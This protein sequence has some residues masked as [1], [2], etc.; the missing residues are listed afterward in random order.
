MRDQAQYNVR[1][2]LATVAGASVPPPFGGK[3][4]QIMV[5]ADRTALEARGLT[6]MDVVHSLNDAN[7]IIPAGDA[8]I[9]NIDYFVGSN[10]MIENPS[11]IDDVPIRVGAGQAPVLVGDVGHADDA[12]QIQQNVVRIDG[13][14]SV[15]V[16]IL[17]QGNANTIAVVDG[18]RAVLPKIVGLPAGMHLQTIFDQ[19]GYIRDAIE[20]LQ[21]EAASAA[22]LASLVI[23]LFLSSFKSTL[24]IFVSIPLSILAAA[25]GLFLNG[26]TTNVMT[27][28][29]FALAIGRLVDNSVVV[30]ENVSRHLAQGKPPEV[31]ARDGAEEV[32]LP[33]LAS[34]V[35][36][37]IVFFPVMFLFGV[38]KYLFGALSLAVVLSMLASYVVAMTVIP[39]YCARFVTAA[40]AAAEAAGAAH[41]RLAW[42]ARAYE[43]FADRYEVWLRAA[44][45]HKWAVI[46][47]V[48][49]LFV[50]AMMGG[51][52][53]GTELFPRTDAGQ[54]IINLRTPPGSR[55]EVTEGLTAQV[56]QI[57]REVVPPHDLGTVVSNLGLAPGFSAIYSPNAASDS[58]FVM[59][60]LTPAHTGATADYVRALRAALRSRLP[61]VQAFFQSGSIIDAVLNFGLAA[62]IDVQLSG[63]DYTAL[64]S[65]AERVAGVVRQLPEV[66]DAFIPQ[67]SAYP[68]LEVNVDRMKAARLGLSQRD[69][70]TNLITALTSNQMIAP[71]IWIDPRTGNDYFLTVQYPEK[72]ISSLDTLLNIPVRG[73][74]RGEDH[75]DAILLR[76]VAEVS[77]KTQPAEA[78]HYN[79]QRVVDVLVAPRGDDLGGAQSG[80]QR[81]LSGLSLPSDIHVTYR[82]SVA[83]MQSSFSSFGFG[84][85]MALVLLYLVMVAQ[86]RSFLDPFIIMFSVPMGLIG[87]VATL[88]AT[89]TTLNIESCMGTIMMVGYRGVEFDPAGRFHQPT[90]ARRRP[91]AAGDRRGVARPHAADHHDRPGDRRRAPAHRHEAGHRLRG[92][93]AAGARRRGRPHRVHR[94]DPGARAG[95]LRAV[96]RAAPGGR[97]VNPSH[98]ALALVALGLVAA[99]CGAPA[100][101]SAAAPEPM[102]VAVARPQP[103]DV[104]RAVSLPGDVI[105]RSEADLYAKVTGYLTH[106]AV[107]KGDWVKKGQVLAELEVPELEQ[108]LKRARANLSVQRVTYERLQRVWDADHR[109]LAR[110][111]VDVA[112]GKLQQ[113][114]AEAEELE[115]EMGYTQIVA[116]FDGVVTARYVDP[117]ALIEANGH[118]SGSGTPGEQ[119]QRS[120]PVP[121]L[122]LADI[123]RL[124]VYVYVPEA[125]TAL[126]RRG[127]PASLRLRE[128]PGREFS[129]VVARFSNSLDLATRTMLTEVDLDNA[130]HELYPG[131]YADVRLELEHRSGVL[132]VP[133]TAVGGAAGGR[134]VFVV[135]DGH[136]AKVPVRTGIESGEWIEIRSGLSG[137]EAVVTNMSPTLADGAPARPALAGGPATRPAG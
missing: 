113:A 19:S 38:V 107:D 15:Y 28:G 87:V 100:V 66:A 14:R 124:R 132:R 59:I 27:L 81:A 135:R 23:L 137:D 74:G 45:E 68:T 8:K 130:S 33:V 2:Q 77:H 61:Q 53:L 31:A 89:G 7:L 6:P 44:L 25:F 125:E 32:A 72:D 85:A 26:S 57:V 114:Q 22:V 129:G 96:L 29:G 131:M 95:G 83:A 52:W 121:V 62:P 63:P 40:E 43:R 65:A 127:Q 106:I 136:L 97:I 58:G 108:R 88:L 5:Y 112:L 115:A 51:G 98:A 3:Y 122:S 48:T 47:G 76:N 133:A 9:G 75:A 1:N 17:K 71:S 78:A 73:D 50:A 37:V 35:T 46:G 55:I 116:P 12:A 70:V 36:T 99:G 110:E 64:H 118:A 128:F 42:F 21:H 82:G 103:G 4:R 105:G 54:F 91:A 20:S 117:G 30:L 120:G 90:P 111:D 60:N 123:D 24:A 84:L 101:G 93:R 86:F 126:V 34:T 11:D 67:E 56:E 13:Q 80:I 134:F 49:V 94:P 92:L 119:R 41:G 79:I 10:S 18:V 69:V 102:R 104:A 39:V 109:L 16:P